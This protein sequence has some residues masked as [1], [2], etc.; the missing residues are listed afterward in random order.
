MSGT[1]VSL[2]VAGQRLTGSFSFKKNATTGV[3]TIGLKNVSLALGNGT[4]TFVTVGIT[5]RRDHD[6][7]RE[8]A[9]PRGGIAAKIGVTLTLAPSLASDIS[10]AGATAEL[11]INTTTQAVST[12]VDVDGT[13]VPLVA[14]AGP[15]VRVT[16]GVG[17]PVA[18]TLKGQS[19]TA[20]VV[21]EQ[22]TTSAGTKVVRVAFTDVGLFLGDAGRGV[23]LVNGSGAVILT[24][25]GI[26]GEVEGTV[27]LEGLPVSIGA[28]LKLQINN[29]GVPV[30]E[31]VQFAGLDSVTDTQGTASVREVQRL[32]VTATSRHVHAGLRQERQRPHRGRRDL[33][34][35]GRRR[36]RRPRSRAALE[37]LTVRAGPDG[38]R[39]HRWVQRHLG[40]QRQPG[41]APRQRPGPGPA[42]RARTCASPPTAWPSPSSRTA[43]TPRVASS[44]SAPTSR[45]SGSGPPGRS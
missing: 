34:G 6:R 11:L 28:T 44:S 37:A 16:V 14:P 25:G 41:A 38:R 24:A 18:V 35:P 12:S 30:A 33:G 2:E 3:I 39:G 22:R 13:P 15:Y 32:L 7:A 1:G 43:W 36:D 8:R 4:T 40:R 45:S 23:R 5:E 19:L 17:A 31:I 9:V 27:T 42:R 21:F 10:V 29:L 20:R 26:A